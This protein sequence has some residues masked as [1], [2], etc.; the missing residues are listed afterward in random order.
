LILVIAFSALVIVSASKRFLYFEELNETTILLANQPF[1]SIYVGNFT[2]ANN[3]TIARIQLIF[4]NLTNNL[5]MKLNYYTPSKNIEVD[6]MSVKFKSP[7]FLN[8]Y[9]KSDPSNV[10]YSFERKIGRIIFKV[11][12][13]RWLGK[14]D[15]DAD[16]HFL[17]RA[18]PDPPYDLQVSIDLHLH[19]V[20]P[21][22]LA[23]IHAHKVVDMT[24]P[25]GKTA[26]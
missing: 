12:D 20:A 9:L 24:F 19:R 13:F 15:G 6:S 10:Q 23:G 1:T 8:V 25:I 4:E 3:N 17:L 18:H 22:Q 21:I 14:V 5:T 26:E 2:D 16:F 7:D 11:E